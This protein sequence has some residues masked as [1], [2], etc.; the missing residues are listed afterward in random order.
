M[1]KNILIVGGGIIVLGAVFLFMHSS[2]EESPVE[3]VIEEIMEEEM[4][5]EEHEMLMAGEHVVVYSDGGYAPKE[6]T[7]KKGDRVTFRNES[8]RETWP[9]SAMHPSHTAYPGSSIGKCG[10]QEESRIFDA[11]KGFKQGEEWS[12]V[13]NEIGNWKYHDHLRSTDWGSVIVE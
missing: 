6:L 4:T 3:E 11:C 7:I 13:F 1:S 5:G 12:F 9:A 8:A 10:T 2:R